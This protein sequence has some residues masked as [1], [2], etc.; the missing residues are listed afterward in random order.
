MYGLTTAPG[1]TI[2]ICCPSG[3]LFCYYRDGGYGMCSKVFAAE[4]S[5]VAIAASY[6][7]SSYSSTIMPTTV[8]VT[9]GT[10]GIT[11]SFI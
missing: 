9:L 2:G 6:F 11:A 3:F 4:T 8:T 1:E 10:Q 7:S 5:V